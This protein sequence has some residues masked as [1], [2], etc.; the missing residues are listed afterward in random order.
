MFEQEYRI[1]REFPYYFLDCRKFSR[2]DG[3]DWTDRFTSQTDVKAGNLYEFYLHVLEDVLS[4]LPALID[5]NEDWVRRAD[6]R[7]G[8][9]VRS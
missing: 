7:V 6:T 4:S 9:A 1:V 8:K 5:M 2:Y 3:A